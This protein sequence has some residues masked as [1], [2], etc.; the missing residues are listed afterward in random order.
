MAMASSMEDEAMNNDRLIIACLR[1]GLPRDE[2]AKDLRAQG[3][4]DLSVEAA[5]G[6]V[7]E[8][9]QLKDWLDRARRLVWE[10][11]SDM[12]QTARSNQTNLNGRD[13]TFPNDSPCKECIGHNVI[14]QAGIDGSMKVIVRMRAFCAEAAKELKA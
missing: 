14:H 10:A 1:E 13:P 3:L 11:A 4:A 5:A 12:Y 7:N 6:L 8:N 2:R 9:E